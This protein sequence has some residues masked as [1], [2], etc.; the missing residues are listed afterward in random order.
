M[1]WRQLTAQD[2]EE[3]TDFQEQETSPPTMSCGMM[4]IKEKVKFGHR[5]TIH[6]PLTVLPGPPGTI[7]LKVLSLGC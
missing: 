5:R 7:F 6:T 4:S 3:S 2:Q 1:P